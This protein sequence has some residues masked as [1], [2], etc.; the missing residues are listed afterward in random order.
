MRDLWKI[1]RWEVFR[2]V[3]NKQFLIGLLL[4]PILMAIFSGVPLVLERINKPALTTYYVVD[5]VGELPHLQTMLPENIVLQ[6]Y[7]DLNSVENSVREAKASGYFVLSPEFFSSGQIALMYNDRNNESLG[8]IRRSLTTLLQQVRLSE[9]EVST[10]QLSFV[11]ASAEV[12]SVAMEEE[13]EPR[14]MHLAVAMVF[15]ILIFFLIFTSGAMLMQSALQE[16]RDRM[17]EVVLSSIRPDKLMQGKIIGHFLLGLIQLTFWLALGVPLA[18]YF[19]KFPILEALQAA[20]YPVILFFGL[21]GY[22][23]FA[24]M[25]VSLGATMEDMQSAGNS[26]GLV[27]MLPMLSFLFLGPVISNPDGTIAIVAS[28]FPFTSPSLMML[29]SGL[30]TVPLWQILLSGLLL[31]LT[32]WLMIFIA[33]KIFRIGMLMYGKNATPKEIMKWLR[34]KD[35]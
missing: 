4:T 23:L 1:A 31:I 32:S 21:G 34:Y 6:E 16:K 35:N 22:L 14:T 19:I 17:A 24:S 13:L 15:T 29:R 27:M 10:E 8:I 5:Q 33:S 11:T 26:Q 9:S 7:Q 2:N 25:F 3:T 18:V 20:N 12:V 28:I 30:T